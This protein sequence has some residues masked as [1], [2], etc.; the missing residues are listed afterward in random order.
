[1]CC[2]L[3][4]G[5]D[6]GGFVKCSF[7]GYKFDEE[8]ADLSCKGCFMT[9]GCRLIKC[10]NCGYEMP[11]EPKWLKKILERRNRDGID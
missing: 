4:L 5:Q 6:R 11:P 2:K 8:K 7:C 3:S 1:V 10:P 9:K